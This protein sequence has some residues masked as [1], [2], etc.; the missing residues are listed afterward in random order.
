MVKRRRQSCSPVNEHQERAALDAAQT[1]IAELRQG[2]PSEPVPSGER[3]FV[4]LHGVRWHR[5]GGTAGLAR[6]RITAL[7]R[8]PAVRVIH[9][10]GFRQD[11]LAPEV[12]EEFWREALAR[13]AADDEV[14]F[15][16]F[17]YKN[18]LGERLLLINN[19]D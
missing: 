16:A 17:E 6:R 18:A 4:D 13:E 19:Y 15:F 9:A 11:E 5:R 10:H 3:E 12:R 7:L 1:Q 2:V 14:E 8:D